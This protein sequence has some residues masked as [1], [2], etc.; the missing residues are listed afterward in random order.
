MYVEDEAVSF[1]RGCV[2]RISVI[3][4]NRNTYLCPAPIG[5]LHVASALSKAGHEVQFIDLMHARNPIQHLEQS[6][7]KHQPE[8]VCMSIRNVDNQQMFNL[9]R[10][11]PEIAK[12]AECVRRVSN[13][14]LLIGGTAVTSFPSQ[15]RAMMGADYAFAGDD[16]TLIVRFVASLQS[17]RPDLGVPGLAFSDAQGEHRN[18]PTLAGYANA[19]FDGIERIELKKYRKGYY[20]CGVLTC[21][22]CPHGCSFCDTYKSFGTVHIPRDPKLIV[23]EMTELER[24][25]GAKSVF[26][27]NAGINYPL[28]HGKELM[29]RLVEARLNLSFACIIEPSAFDAEMAQL[30]YRANCSGAM[31]FGSSLDDSVLERNQPHYRSCDVQRIA[32]LLRDANVPV[33]LG[34]MFGG[35]GETIAGVKASLDMA[36]T[37]RPE[38]MICGTGFRIQSGTPLQ[39]EAIRLGQISADDDCFEPKFFV[40]E[41]A[42]PQEIRETVQRFMR[43][44]PSVALRMVGY[45]V[46]TTREGIFGRSGRFASPEG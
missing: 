45:L 17:G 20:D 15:V 10:P 21:S 23:E 28:E 42:T 24:R 37:L 39:A 46:R 1:E 38:M 5:A 13:A 30:L 25:H 16:V 22:G 29:R 4:S 14:P 6:L 12:L 31:I 9:D 32:K 41:E 11:L 34:L 3:Y 26:L 40:P 18:P 36:H 27:V 43:R 7:A 35:M 2:V 44:H 33:L 8:L 19:R